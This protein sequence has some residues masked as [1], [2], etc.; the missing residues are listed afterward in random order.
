M[1]LLAVAASLPLGPRTAAAASAAPPIVPG[2]ERFFSGD[3]A[4]VAKGGQLLLGELNCVSCHQP[5]DAPLSRKQAP[6]LDNVAGR[7]RV[8]YL[9][10]FL[11]DP[12][13]IKPGTT[14]P[15]LFADDREKAAKVEALVHFLATTGSLKLTRPDP[16]IVGL[17]KDIFHKV[18]CVAC[19]GPRDDKGQELKT[20]SVV[21]PLGDLAV[22]YSILSLATFLEQPHQVRPS[23][24]MPQIVAG[25][26]AKDVATYLLQAAKVDEQAR[27]STT[28]AYYEGTWDKVPDF[29]KLKPNATGSSGAFSLGVAKRGDNYA[30]KFEGFFKIDRDGE[31]KFSVNSDDGSKLYV[32][33]QQVVDN[34]GVHPPHG[35]QRVG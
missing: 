1:L 25:K 6:V 32:D 18:G 19:H 10:K 35:G 14:M 15:N 4:D 28:Y 9:K 12:Q 17:G 11:S 27:G 16:K 34:D 29:A 20:T 7:T 26:D 24:R 22:K 31:Y 30:I 33:G 8:S 21:V 3:K 23:G 13:A 2:F 5:G